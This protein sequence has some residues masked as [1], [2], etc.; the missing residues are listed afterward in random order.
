[1]QMQQLSD[2]QKE[3]SGRVREIMNILASVTKKT[4]E[5]TASIG[6]K[7]GQIRKNSKRIVRGQYKT[8][9]ELQHI[10]DLFRT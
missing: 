7:L 5:L 2:S 10:T 3:K 1:M 4:E 9:R 8:L 6:Y